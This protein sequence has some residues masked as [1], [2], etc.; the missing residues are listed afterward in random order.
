MA[1]AVKK[2]KKETQR[3]FNVS[4][5]QGKHISHQFAALKVSTK[6]RESPLYDTIGR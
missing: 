1:N 3:D 5:K 4:K 6:I 2:R